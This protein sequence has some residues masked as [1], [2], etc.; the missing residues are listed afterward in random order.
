MTTIISVANQK[1]GVGKSTITR[2]LAASCAIRG[3]NVLAVDCD[4]QG[5]LTKSLFA[6]PDICETHLIHT[7]LKPEGKGNNLSELYPLKA[8]I[9]ETPIENLDFVGSDNRLVRFEREP[10]SAMNRLKQQ[11]NNHA[12][13]YDLIFLDCPPN[14]GILLHA[15]LYASKYVLIPCAPLSMSLEGLTDL[16]Y[17][18]GEVREM[19]PNLEVLGPVINLYKPQRYISKDARR[20]VEELNELLGNIF[21]VNLHD[22]S[23]FADAHTRKLP[24]SIF[25]HRSKAAE[26]ISQFTDEFLDRLGLARTT[27]IAVINDSEKL[28]SVAI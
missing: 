18:I 17:T 28:L 14:L 22:L 15:A 20:A 25:A 27:K 11:L 21:T 19:N 1:G 7:L 12:S 8:A 13:T 6:D 23:E 10:A 9:Y 24:V 5:S 26:Q 4:P 3:Y 16:V 2:E